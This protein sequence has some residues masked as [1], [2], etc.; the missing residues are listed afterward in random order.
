M[1]QSLPD[2]K[3]IEESLAVIHEFYNVRHVSE[4]IDLLGPPTV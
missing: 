1:P 2:D 4:L 3:R